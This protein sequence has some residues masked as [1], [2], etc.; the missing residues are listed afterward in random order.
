MNEVKITL[1]S[2]QVGVFLD[3]RFPFKIHTYNGAQGFD[4]FDIQKYYGGSDLVPSEIKRVYVSNDLC[5]D[6]RTTIRAIQ[7]EAREIQLKGTNR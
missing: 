5:Y 4:L 6:I 2:Y 7:N 1:P 3:P